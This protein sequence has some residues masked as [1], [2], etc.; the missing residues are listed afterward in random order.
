[1]QKILCKTDGK[2]KGG[3]DKALL[4][5]RIA[6]GVVFVLHG[7]G[8]LT[9]NPSLEM[10]SGMLANIGF[11]MPMF[12]SWVVALTE[13]LGGLALIAGIFT[14]PAGV[15]L[16]CVMVVAITAVKKLSFPMADPDLALLGIALALAFAGPGRFSVAGMMMK[17]KEQDS[18]CC[19]GGECCK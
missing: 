4:A 2:C 6:A 3:K 18:E 5:I 12:F 13:F 15:L 1:M 10:F 17:G 9:G 7:Y 11:P 14:R 19:K 16:F 8:K